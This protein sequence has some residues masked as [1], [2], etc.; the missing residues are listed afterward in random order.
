MKP[1]NQLSRFG[2][3]MCRVAEILV[4]AEPV[5]RTKRPDTLL[6]HGPARDTRLAYNRRLPMYP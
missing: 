6:W 2:Q 3:A 1:L 5:C 4:A